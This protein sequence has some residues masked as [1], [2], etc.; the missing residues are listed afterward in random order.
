MRRYRSA[1]RLAVCFALVAACSD[2]A[3]V[4]PVPE[5]HHP[6]DGAFLLDTYPSTPPVPDVLASGL[7]PETIK[8][9]KRVSV[10]RDSFPA[11]GPGVQV[12][13]P[14]TDTIYDPEPLIPP[15]DEIAL[16]LVGQDFVFSRDILGTPTYW[17]VVPGEVKRVILGPTQPDPERSGLRAH[18]VVQLIAEQCGLELEGT[19]RFHSDWFGRGALRPRSFTPTSRRRSGECR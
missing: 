15:E 13:V 2:R 17:R 19:L 5:E 11:A 1:R 16:W 7:R 14:I 8:K 6:L 10:V 18:M 3:P 12:L 4:P 9:L